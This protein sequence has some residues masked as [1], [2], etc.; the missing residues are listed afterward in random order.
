VPKTI[1]S[2]R[3]NSELEQATRPKHELIMFYMT[4]III[5]NIDLVSLDAQNV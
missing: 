2:F 5:L 4:V 3:S 1:Y